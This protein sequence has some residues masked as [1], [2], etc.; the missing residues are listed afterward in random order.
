MSA[1]SGI[2]VSPDLTAA[3]A[4]ALKYT[5]V[6]FI[7]VSIQNESLVHELTVDAAGSFEDDLAK[8]QDNEILSD[9]VPAYV[10][11]KLDPPST[12]WT[13]FS[14]VPDHA[15][16]RD[17]MLYASSRASLFKSLG[18]T[19]FTDSIY[20]TSKADLT[21]EAYQAHLRHL[22]APKPLSTR[23]Q[24]M[25]DVRAAESGSAS[26]EGSRT[27]VTH[28]GSG[29]G[30]KWAPEV[31]EA[32]TNLGRG[33]NCEIIVLTIDPETETVLLKS[34]SEIT[35][36]ELASSVPKNE[37]C[38]ALLAWP[39]SYTSPPRR[40]IVFI[41]SCPSSSP[42]KHRMLYSTGSGS[43][44]R[45][46]KELLVST[47]P[48]VQF[49]ARKIETSDPQELTEN[50]IVEELGLKGSDPDTLGGNG[51]ALS[52]SNDAPKTFARP[53]GPPRRR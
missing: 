20:A 43:T 5:S 37:P 19:L 35:I 48:T 18:S 31:E 8:L 26:Y 15:K 47:C 23:E 10:L 3:F 51:G 36:N 42:I 27:R 28:V 6:R 44:Q 14:Y 33:D 21:A 1:S 30:F 2:A 52:R 4:D 29:V 9:T 25:A 32:V 34:N 17:K 53:K 12:D 11:A 41:Y 24:E 16:V 49:S 38:Y 39:Q 50:Y 22:A 45:W 46:A 7:K 40:E 13:A